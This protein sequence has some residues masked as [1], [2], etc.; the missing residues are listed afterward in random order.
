MVV[1]DVPEGVY[2]PREDSWLLREAV[3]GL[4]LAGKRVCDMGTGSGILA[5]TAA[6]HGAD[7]TL[8]DIH[9]DALEAAEGLLE[10]HGFHA[11]AVRSDLFQDVDG[12]FDIIVFNP[13]YVPG[14]EELG[15]MEEKAWAGGQRGRR[16]TDR[17]IAQ[18][19]DHLEPGGEVYLL[20]SSRNDVQE[21]VQRFAEQGFRAEIV[22][23]TKVPW[24]KLVVVR[25]V[26]A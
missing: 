19:G 5:L 9:P 11:E 6:E 23:E 25:A 14:E 13:P 7:V 16:V 26:R 15:T 4:D 24:E 3:A 17:F 22:A 18:V 1:K 10:Q 12:T 8:V 2:E 21:T 20:Q